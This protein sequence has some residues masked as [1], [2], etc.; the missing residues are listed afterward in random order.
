MKNI[1]KSREYYRSAWFCMITF[2]SYE[3]C[4]MTS[5]AI[6]NG[7]PTKVLRLLVVLVNWPATPKSASFTSPISLNK[8]F[9]A[10][11]QTIIIVRNR[12]KYILRSPRL[13]KNIEKFLETSLYDRFER[14]LKINA[15]LLRRGSTD[16]KTRENH[17]EILEK[18]IELVAFKY[19]VWS[20]RIR[21]FY[22]QLSC[23]NQNYYPIGA[24][25]DTT[26]LFQAKR[27]NPLIPFFV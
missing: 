3:A 26:V 23:D 6:Q 19:V 1:Q 25:K 8:T 17:A 13:S 2:E 7:V 10:E 15:I 14:C 18:F 24:R 9:A 4:L 12:N 27:L 5:G 21:I 16:L 11:R 20:Y 22:L